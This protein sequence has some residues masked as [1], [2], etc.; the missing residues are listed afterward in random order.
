VNVVRLLIY[1]AVVFL[2]IGLRIVKADEW[3]VVMR[4]GKYIGFR[5]Q[6]IHWVVPFVDK[7]VR[8]GLDQVSPSWKDTPDEILE[9]AVHK[10]ISEESAS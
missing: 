5:K 8:V 2:L 9:T 3:L 4:F 6:G 1:A 7:T 10:W